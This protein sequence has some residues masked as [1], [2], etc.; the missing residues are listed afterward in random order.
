MLW[1]MTEVAMALKA[2]LSFAPL[3][4]TICPKTDRTSSA[5][6]MK[7]VDRPAMRAGILLD[8]LFLLKWMFE[9]GQ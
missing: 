9:S 8:K 2:L 7:N 5:I 1:Q 3:R 6:K 4:T